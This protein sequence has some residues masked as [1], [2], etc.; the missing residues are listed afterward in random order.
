MRCLP[1]PSKFLVIFDLTLCFPIAG[2]TTTTADSFKY[3]VGFG[4]IVGPMT[5]ISLER[6]KS[7]DELSVRIIGLNSFPFAIA[8]V[9]HNRIEIMNLLIPNDEACL[10]PIKVVSLRSIHSVW[11]LR[12]LRPDSVY[13]SRR[14]LRA[15]GCDPLFYGILHD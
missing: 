5:S 7:S 15:C 4:K 13:N 8:S 14:N 12:S 6:S 1:E 11:Q 9:P 3:L 2:S 10:F